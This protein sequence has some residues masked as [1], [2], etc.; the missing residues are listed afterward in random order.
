MPLAAAHQ[1]N[2]SDNEEEGM[3]E[4]GE[5]NDSADIY[6]EI[7]QDDNEEDQNSSKGVSDL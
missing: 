6:E 2:E 5:A 4:D 1:Q 3:G 7:D